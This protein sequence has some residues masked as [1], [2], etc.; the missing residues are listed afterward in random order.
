MAN[1]RLYFVGQ[2]VSLVGTWMQMVAQSWLVLVLTGSATWVGAVVA[3]QT[4]PILL[5]GPYGGVVAD[6]SDK[7][8]LLV[9]LQ[10]V[11]GVLA[12][13]LAVLTLSG[14]VRVWQVLV[15]AGA[16]GCADAFEKPARQAFVIEIVGPQ[17]LRNAVSLNSVMVNAARILGPAVAGLI[18]AAGGIGLCF[19][20]NAV[21]Y[22]PVALLLM[23]M[24]RAALHPSTPQAREPGQ[25]RAGLA[26]VRRHT[27]LAVPLVMMAIIGCFTYEFQVSLPAMAHTSLSGDARTYG[28]MTAA[29]GV[30]AVVG[31]LHTAARGRTGIATMVRSATGF[32]IVVLAAAVAPGVATELLAL[33]AVGAAS[34]SLM[35]RGNSTLQ[36]SADPGMRGRVMALWLVAFQGTTPIGGPIVGWVAEQAGP[37][38]ALVLGAAACFVAAGIGAAALHRIRDGLGVAGPRGILP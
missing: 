33:V 8:R 1:F 13:V 25:V 12:L 16:L 29:M 15:L 31:G 30:G 19:L 18:I 6:R 26:H 27:Q 21:S 3:V 20:V 32:G 5:L 10:V 24:D 9:G 23:L 4:L 36:L 34:V 2:A 38:W 14:E 22:L 11:M 17:H 28:F 7:R 37:R 35:A